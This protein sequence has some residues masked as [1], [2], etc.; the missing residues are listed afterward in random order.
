MKGV[1]LSI[2][3]SLQSLEFHSLLNLVRTGNFSSNGFV[4]LPQIRLLYVDFSKIL[5]TVH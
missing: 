2:M 4:C 1:I 3:L 5:V